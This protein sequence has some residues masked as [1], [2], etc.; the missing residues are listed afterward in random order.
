MR[1]LVRG[2]RRLC[3]KHR[4]DMNIVPEGMHRIQIEG[5]EENG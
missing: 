3:Y 2:I 1:T 5:Q 4:Y